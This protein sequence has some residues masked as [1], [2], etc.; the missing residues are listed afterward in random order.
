M[1]KIT[2]MTKQTVNNFHEDA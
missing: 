2:A 1:S